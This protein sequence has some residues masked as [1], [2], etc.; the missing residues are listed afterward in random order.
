MH[1]KPLY[2]AGTFLLTDSILEV[3]SP[4]DGSVVAIV[5]QGG[6]AEVEQAIAAAEVSLTETRAL[7]PHVRGAVLTHI[8]RRMGERAEEFAQALTTENGKTIKEARIEAARA[9]STFQIAAGEAWKVHGEAYDA[10]IVPS[11]AG[12]R[13]LVRKFPIGVVAGI[14]PFNFPLNLAAHKV[15]PAIAAGCPIVLKPASKTPLTGL[16]L[17]ELIAETAWPKGAFSCI[18]CG[19]EAGQLL[20]EDDR[21]KLLSFTGSGPVGWKMKAQAGMKKVVLELGGNAGLIV[22]KDVRDWDWAISR[23]VAGAFTQAGQS[24][25]SVQR[26]FCHEAVYDEFKRRLVE[27]AQ[28]LKAG[29]PMDEATTVAPLIDAHNRDRVLAWIDEAVQNGATLLCGGTAVGNAVMPALLEGVQPNMKLSCDEVFG[30]VAILE[31]VASVDKAIDRVN[32]SVFGLQCGILSHDFGAIQRAFNRLEVGGL[33][34]GD[35][36]SFRVDHMP[37][38]GVKMSGLGREGVRYAM[39]DMLEP[40]V[41]VY[42][43]TF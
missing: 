39:E 18:P 22:D 40:K 12:R 41:M 1:P 33:V 4:Y 25:I 13:I 17:A 27:A 6:K 7:E 21:I 35:V 34:V 37:Y 23:T 19:R 32:D 10:G 29:D 3:K 43:S 42:P 24:C 8:A 15:A 30:P 20:V 5:A 16:L 9:I 28:K 11:A 38:G 26:I 31:K 36:P 2:L 14:A